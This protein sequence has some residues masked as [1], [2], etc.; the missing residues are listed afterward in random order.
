MKTQ[1]ILVILLAGLI[2]VPAFGQSRRDNEEA[3]LTNA[4]EIPAPATFETT[5]SKLDLEIPRPS[6]I[7]DRGFAK[8]GADQPANSL[9]AVRRV[10]MTQEPR[11][12]SSDD[13]LSLQETVEKL[14]L[15]VRELEYD[16]ESKLSAAADEDKNNEADS[17]MAT[18]LQ[19]SIETIQS[20]LAD[21]QTAFDN[22]LPRLIFH[23][24]NNPRMR[25]FGRIHLDYWAFPQAQSTLF[26]LEGGNPQDRFV[27]R[28]LRI[29]V[30]G[31]L[32][33]NMFDRYEG[34][35]ALGNDPSYQD[36]FI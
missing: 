11:S 29:G 4:F 6:P 2:C 31:D 23:N 20:D 13:E 16:V 26:P 33:D 8:I 19:K 28:R 14:Q 18:D 7:V 3:F 27:F 24:H 10:S 25:F 22:L 15:R 36:A 17:E 35:F 12:I 34:E 32:N 21:Q 9:S 1:N 30:E 5:N